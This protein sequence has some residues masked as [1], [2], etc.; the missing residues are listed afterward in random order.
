LDTFGDDYRMQWEDEL[1]PVAAWERP[2]R[3]PRMAF[4]SIDPK[5]RLVREGPN[6][7]RIE[8]ASGAPRGSLSFHLITLD[9]MALKVVLAPAEGPLA[10]ARR[11]REDLPEGF[12]ATIRPG[13][14][15]SA[16]ASLSFWRV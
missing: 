2:A 8:G 12:V 7:L 1:T 15:A 11:I 9:E 13:R 3:M 5:Q 10:V 16:A 14:P 6:R 4:L